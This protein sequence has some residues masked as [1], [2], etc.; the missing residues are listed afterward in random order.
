MG[1][2]P[3]FGS[4]CCSL[5]VHGPLMGDRD[6]VTAPSH[7]A[8]RPSSRAGLRLL[9]VGA[10]LALG[11][12]TSSVPATAVPSCPTVG[13]D[14]T[15]TP[16]ITPG[17]DMSGC[18]LT[19]ANLTGADL[20]GVDFDGAN[21]TNA[22]L[23]GVILDNARLTAT[24]TGVRSG[25]IP[26][27]VDDISD[28]AVDWDISGGFLLGPG[29]NLAGADLRAADLA[30]K[31]LRGANLSGAN[32]SGGDL[33]GTSFENA[34]LSGADLSDATLT[35]VGASEANFNGANLRGAD[36]LG[37]V[38]SSADM[39]NADFS[40]ATLVGPP[41]SLNPTG[42]SGANFTGA[43]LYQVVIA[44][45]TYDS[46]GSSLTVTYYSDASATSVT[47]ESLIPGFS[48]TT[49]SSTGLGSGDTALAITLPQSL[50]TLDHYALGYSAATTLTF[51][52]D[53]PRNESN[54]FG[55]SDYVRLLQYRPAY[56]A[57]W[58]PSQEGEPP[59]PG[60]VLVGRIPGGPVVRKAICQVT[61]SAAGSGVSGTPASASAL[62]TLWNQPIT[63][64][65]QGTLS[66]PGYT[67]AGWSTSF[68]GSP[69]GGTYLPTRTG[70]AGATCQDTVL[71]S[72]WTANPSGGGSSSATTS[73]TTATTPPAITTVS[74]VTPP[75]ASPTTVSRGQA[76]ATI[77]GVP[78]EVTRTS[79]PA[80][81][82]FS[83]TAGS[84]VVRT[85]PPPTGF[86]AG[87]ISTVTMSG[88]APDSS[89]GAFLF[90]EPVSLG[91]LTVD[92]EGVATGR[93]VI[94]ASVLP[95]DHTLQVTGWTPSGEPVI[96]SAGVTVKPEV[97]RVVTP[98][99]FA[100]GA[101]TLRGPGRAAVRR[102]VAGTAAMVG[103]WRTTVAYPEGDGDIGRTRARAVAS[104]LRS[105][106]L[107]GPI[108]VEVAPAGRRAIPAGMVTI[109]T[110]RR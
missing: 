53:V 16:A 81:G 33:N 97:T 99:P 28:I 17:A 30:W 22:V 55:G 51:L 4:L 11:S 7:Q 88:F 18:N 105:G 37:S 59:S 91:T 26:T 87:G 14:G 71:Y 19:G 2:D 5:L 1:L 9:L 32:L 48:V 102:A 92:A 24:L 50:T 39:T 44:P 69:V 63:V 21:L 38:F 109:T 15:V 101:S 45:Y 93:I 68:D 76:A 12:V 57:N 34:D 31:R 35:G 46:S 54:S 82:G 60:D 107:T 106:G 10:L 90:S 6:L 70:D 42:L 89:A 104:A 13:V 84:M 75:G 100:D 23:T 66:R 98:V 20:T 78:T 72:T 73:T 61:F 74:V 77:G 95:G 49:I 110:T 85:S 94:P 47:F 27:T 67:F 108:R 83:L 3:H 62:Q 41:M 36:I 80:G 25:E 58:K 64:S 65:G 96:L 8:P 29:A 43:T 52:G 40:E 103:P 56:E 86:S 79:G